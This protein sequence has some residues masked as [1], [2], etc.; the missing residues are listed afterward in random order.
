MRT[1]NTPAKVVTRFVADR[2]IPLQ[3]EILYPVTGDLDL[4]EEVDFEDLAVFTEAWKSSS[5]DSNWN[6]DCDL[7]DPKDNIIDEKDLEEFVSNWLTGK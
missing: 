7:S 4:N 5:G 1:T 3:H 6:S 2:L